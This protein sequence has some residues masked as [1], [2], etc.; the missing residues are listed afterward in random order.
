MGIHHEL[1]RYALLMH[2]IMHANNAV[3]N[4]NQYQ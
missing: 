1:H 2:M 4:D 3:L